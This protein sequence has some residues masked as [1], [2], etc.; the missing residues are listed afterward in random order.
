MF[1]GK[2]PESQSTSERVQ[3]TSTQ[4][5]REQEGTGGIGGRGD[6][7]DELGNTMSPKNFGFLKRA[8]PSSLNS[9]DNHRWFKELWIIML[10]RGYSCTFFKFSYKGFQGILGIVASTP[11]I[12]ATEL[13]GD[14]P[15]GRTLWGFLLTL[16]KDC[17]C[18]VT[19]CSQRAVEAGGLKVLWFRYAGQGI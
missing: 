3:C 18:G 2:S 13:R 9:I 17:G 6:V 15:Q 19:G 11:W 4:A 5:F 14:L 10:A 1:W 16:L 8:S 12:T 7:G